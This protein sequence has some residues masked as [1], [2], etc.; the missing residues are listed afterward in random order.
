MLDVC[1]LDECI[2]GSKM[3]TRPAGLLFAD[4]ITDL[5]GNFI[6][7]IHVAIDDEKTF[8]FVGHNE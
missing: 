6:L 3:D 8:V 4:P 5:L 1:K 2:V 7:M